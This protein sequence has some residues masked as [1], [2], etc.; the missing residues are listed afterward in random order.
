MPLALA[1]NVNASVFEPDSE[2]EGEATGVNALEGLYVLCLLPHSMA[3]TQCPVALPAATSRPRTRSGPI[4]ATAEQQAHV[5]T[6]L[7]TRAMH[8]NAATYRDT[9]AL[10]RTWEPARAALTAGRLHRCLAHVHPSRST[11]RL[12]C[13]G[14][15]GGFAAHHVAVRP[16]HHHASHGSARVHPDTEAH[17]LCSAGEIWCPARWQAGRAAHSP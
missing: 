3:G 1:E 4:C 16:G 17:A 2:A 10:G 8:S 6:K 13:S 7:Q 15:D 14:N 5:R 11:A 12:E 9:F